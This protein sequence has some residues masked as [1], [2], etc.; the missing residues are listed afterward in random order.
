VTPG[1]DTIY[2][3]NGTCS[4]TNDGISGAITGLY[5]YAAT[6]NFVPGSIALSGAG[7]SFDDLSYPAGDSPLVCPGYP[8][9]GGDLDVFGLLFNVAGGFTAGVWSDGVI[10]GQG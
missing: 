3:I 1:A 4:D 5:N 10:P 6:A 2:A 8:F 9:S 7:M